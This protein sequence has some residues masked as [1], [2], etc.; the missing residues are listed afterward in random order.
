MRLANIRMHGSK[1]SH[2]LW[3][4]EPSRSLQRPMAASNRDILTP[5]AAYL[6]II[7]EGGGGGAEGWG[8][9]LPRLRHMHAVV[10]R[11]RAVFV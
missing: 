10:G 11:R 6:S 1:L 5:F 2:I 7:W 3:D 8:F 4:H 9:F